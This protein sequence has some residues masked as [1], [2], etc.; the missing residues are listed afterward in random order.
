MPDW[1][2]QRA[3]RRC[4]AT[5]RP[6]EPGETYYSALVEEGDSFKRLDFSLAAW[7]EQDTSGFFS[8]WRTRLPEET[9]APRRRFVDTAVI[10][11]FFTRLE[12]EESPAKQTFRY[13]L[14]LILIRKRFLRL[15]GIERD[16][17]GEYLA[18]HDRRRDR[19]LQ[20]RNPEPSAEALATAQ[21]ELGCIFDMD[22]DDEGF[23]VEAADAVAAEGEEPA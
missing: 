7:P 14:A 20:V 6:L 9:E 8:F 16:A 21:Q 22:L 19:A 11:A 13:L 3:T 15:D 1:H 18:V 5:E 2:V 10:H 17:A 4:A 23:G 12:E